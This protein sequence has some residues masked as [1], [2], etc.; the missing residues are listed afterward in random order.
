MSLRVLDPR[1]AV[2]FVLVTLLAGCV[3]DDDA[4]P[5]AGPAVAHTPD[6]VAVTAT[7]GSIQGS[8]SSDLF[9]PLPGARVTI[10]ETGLETTVARNGFFTI[11]EV[12]PGTYQLLASIDGYADE[13]RSV[14]VAAGQVSDV[15]FQLVPLAVDR[16]WSEL[17]EQSGM[18]IDGFR[19]QVE[20]GGECQYV[21]QLPDPPGDLSSCGGVT[22]SVLSDVHPMVGEDVATM[23]IEVIWEPA[24]PLGE[25][26]FLDYFCPDVDS[27]AGV[28]ES[29]HP[30]Y[31]KAP[32]QES[33]L[34]IRLDQETWDLTRGN[35]TGEW[36][37]RVYPGY[38]ML[39]TYG[40][41]GLDAGVTYQQEFTFY[42]SFFHGAPAPEGYTALPDA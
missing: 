40:T 6:Q 20:V 18:I 32:G 27:G 35:W 39:G 24:G 8:V 34:I 3:G 13:T 1:L 12:D 16:S 26:L 31:E 4:Q 9:E 38:G 36:T 30:C 23:L 19:Y 11:N 10:I 33:P 37:G 17:I 29:A 22:S 15:A 2:G 42:Q 21:D 14:T 5:D 25:F 41:T 28:A 7:T